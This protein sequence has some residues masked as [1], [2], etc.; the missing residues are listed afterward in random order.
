M[1]LKSELKEGIKAIGI[2]MLVMVA[3][4]AIRMA[5]WMPQIF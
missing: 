3:A 2:M 1:K 5:I 4:M